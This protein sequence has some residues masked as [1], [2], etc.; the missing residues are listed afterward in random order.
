MRGPGAGAPR[1]LD[2]RRIT[3]GSDEK[4]EPP[5]H[6]PGRGTDR[7]VSALSFCPVGVRSMSTKSAPSAPFVPT[8]PNQILST[9]EVAAWLGVETRAVFR[10]GVPQLRLGHKT[11]RYRVRDV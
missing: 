8:N 7:W 9:E 2:A 11:K 10:L 5:L 4:A 6:D 1:H 3:A